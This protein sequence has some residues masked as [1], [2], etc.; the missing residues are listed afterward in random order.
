YDIALREA[1]PGEA[2]CDLGAVRERLLALGE[3]G[4]TTRLRLVAAPLRR[5]L[6]DTGEIPGFGWAT[7]QSVDGEPPPSR[8]HWLDG[9][10]DLLNEHL[11]VQIDQMT[12]TY[13]IRTADGL[14]IEGLGRLAAG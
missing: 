5:V 7:F 10:L 1:G 8:V 11:Q 3:S 12:A 4:H 13:S 2:A 9:H 14:H 6:F